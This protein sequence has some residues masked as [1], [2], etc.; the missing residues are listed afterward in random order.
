MSIHIK[1]FI[2][3]AKTHF[4]P[5]RSNNTEEQG[6]IKFGSKRCVPDLFSFVQGLGQKKPYW[7][8]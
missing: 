2:F 5:N 7:G 4:I 1:K 6:H 3:G 8:A